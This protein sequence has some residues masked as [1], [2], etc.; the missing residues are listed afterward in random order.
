MTLKFK[1]IISALGLAAI[2]SACGQD[3]PT[4]AP[5]P[6]E[7]MA[8]VAAPAEPVASGPAPAATVATSDALVSAVAPD[9]AAAPVTAGVDAAALYK[10]KCASC[11]GKNLEGLAGNPKLTGLSV[12]EFEA[13]LNDYRAGK[14]VGP[15]SAIM[16]AM[17]KPLTDDQVAALA[18]KFGK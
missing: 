1:P 14:Q 7:A 12:A 10:S 9:P 15:K 4:E 2:L 13:R 11:H 5:A 3:K 18:A 16:I 17:A 8:P 6:V